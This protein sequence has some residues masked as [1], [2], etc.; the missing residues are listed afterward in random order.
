VHE[1]VVPIPVPTTG[2]EQ[3]PLVAEVAVPHVIGAGV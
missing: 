1:S 2:V 3:V